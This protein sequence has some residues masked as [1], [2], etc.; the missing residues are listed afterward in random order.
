MSCTDEIG[1]I[2]IVAARAWRYSAAPRRLDFTWNPETGE[3][4]GPD[5]AAVFDRAR[6]A[7]R[8]GFARIHP[9]P[10]SVPIS[11][12]LHRPAELAAVLACDFRLPDWLEVLLPQEVEG[13]GE[14]TV[15]V[16]F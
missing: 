2:R 7:T 3:L 1:P 4:G 9:D 6:E 12:P 11:D 8:E 13:G 14:S 5:A 15:A 10:T 16:T